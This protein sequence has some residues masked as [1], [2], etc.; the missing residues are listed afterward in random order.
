MDRLNA[1]IR[2]SS[3]QPAQV[4]CETCSDN[5]CEVCFAAQHRKGSR[6][7][8]ATKPLSGPQEK[9]AKVDGNGAVTQNGHA[10]NGE[11]VRQSFV[12]HLAGMYSCV[13]RLRCMWT[14]QPQTR[15]RS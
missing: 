12:S 4:F 2:V 10:E 15:M 9:K 1:N 3:D 6:K 11:E 14:T 8:H 13:R 7:R 5:F